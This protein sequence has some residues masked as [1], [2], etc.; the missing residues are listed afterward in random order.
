[1]SD[2]F[3]LQAKHFTNGLRV[4]VSLGDLSPRETRCPPGT[5]KAVVSLRKFVLPS[6]LWVFKSGK[7]ELDLGDRSMRFRVE[8]NPALRGHLNRDVGNHVVS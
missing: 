3:E 6:P 1:L 8:R 5:T 4:F 2:P 7:I